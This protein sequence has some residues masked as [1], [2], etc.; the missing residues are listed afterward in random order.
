MKP[1]AKNRYFGRFS[2]TEDQSPTRKIPQRR[3]L[4]ESLDV[5]EVQIMSPFFEVA[6]CRSV[7]Q[8]LLPV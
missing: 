1:S 4:T 8:C 5:H 6:F 2:N 3:Q 7:A